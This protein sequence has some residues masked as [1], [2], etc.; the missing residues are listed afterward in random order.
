M[1]SRPVRPLRTG[2]HQRVSDLRQRQADGLRLPSAG[3]ERDHELVHRHRAIDRVLQGRLIAT[4]EGS[5]MEAGAIRRAAVVLAR[6]LLTCVGRTGSQ[7][8]IVSGYDRAAR[9]NA[10]NERLWIGFVDGLGSRCL[11]GS[12][13][14]WFSFIY[15]SCPVFFYRTY[16]IWE[17]A[18]E[19]DCGRG[20]GTVD[21]GRASEGVFIS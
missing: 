13:R 14:I 6:G 7:R 5:A 11:V 1:G 21:R 18:T 15:Y 4:E 9:G 8:G 17:N 2:G 12:P 16:C 20:H 3:G 19:D 10:S